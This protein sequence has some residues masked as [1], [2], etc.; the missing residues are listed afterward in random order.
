MHPGSGDREISCF[1]PHIDDV[2]WK[3]N[4]N[5]LTKLT[6]LLGYAEPALL[7]S[8]ILVCHWKVFTDSG[9]S[10]MLLQLP[11]GHVNIYD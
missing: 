6:A 9:E 5:T 2:V 3:N 1:E 10:S 11:V 8:R 7:S 4:D